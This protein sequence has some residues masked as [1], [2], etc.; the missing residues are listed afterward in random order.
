MPIRKD[1]K[2]T[3]IL[4]D[5]NLQPSE[6]LAHIE[7]KSGMNIQLWRFICGALVFIGVLLRYEDT[8]PFP[9]GYDGLF[10]E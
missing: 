1:G 4:F 3:Y 6:I 9:V 8:M 7:K 10:D 5:K 2:A